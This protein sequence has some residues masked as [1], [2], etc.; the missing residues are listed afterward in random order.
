MRG[1]VT[2]LGDHCP[3]ATVPLLQVLSPLF[4]YRADLHGL[5]HQLSLRS[6]PLP[7]DVPLEWRPYGLCSSEEPYDREALDNLVRGA[8]GRLLLPDVGILH[9][10]YEILELVHF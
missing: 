5:I 10:R 2:A 8:T 1:L 9:S 3:R 4:L 7:C 6:F